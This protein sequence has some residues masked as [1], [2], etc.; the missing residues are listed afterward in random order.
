MV[1]VDAEV[2]VLV[3]TPARLYEESQD[4]WTAI[5][6]SV[7]SLLNDGGEV[8][9]LMQGQ[10]KSYQNHSE[11]KV[12]IPRLNESAPNNRNPQ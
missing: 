10:S 3:I 11:N 12:V 2:F 5:A 6:D 9:S 4:K 7:R 8:R 1:K